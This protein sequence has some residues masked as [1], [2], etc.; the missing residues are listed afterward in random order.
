LSFVTLKSRACE[1]GSELADHFFHFSVL[2]IMR[3]ASKA[4]GGSDQF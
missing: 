4:V 1:F 3:V 2:L